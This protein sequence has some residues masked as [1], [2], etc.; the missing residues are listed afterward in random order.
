MRSR[1]VVLVLLLVFLVAAGVQAEGTGI[2]AKGIKAGVN[3]AGHYGD[4]TDEHHSSR[5]AFA[6][7]GFLRYAFAPAWVLQTELLYSQKGY[8]WDDGHSKWTGKFDYLEIPILMT[9]MFQLEGSTTPGLYAGI[10]PAFL[11]SAKE[12]WEYNNGNDYGV[13]A[14]LGD[15]GSEDVKDDSN[16]FDF[17]LVFGGGVDFAV[18]NGLLIFDVRYTMGMTKVYDTEDDWDIKNKAFTILAGYGFK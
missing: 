8:E 16:S 7:G 12:E 18:G 11:M 2:T 14:L 13:A 5:T 1:I 10:S 17:G 4:D 15:S 6:G 9:Y 3:I